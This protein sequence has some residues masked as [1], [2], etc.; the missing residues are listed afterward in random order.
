MPY[1]IR[2]L[3]NKDLYKVV[4]KDT[5]EVHSSGSTYQNAIKQVRLLYKLERKRTGGM[6][7]E[8]E[9][10]PDTLVYKRINGL[11]RQIE[12]NRIYLRKKYR[13]RQ[14]D[15]DDELEDEET[16]EEKADFR[17]ITKINNELERQIE[18]LKMSNPDTNILD[19]L[20]KRERTG[21]GARSSR[22]A[23]AGG[24]R[25][26][27]EPVIP[28]APV[29]ISPNES[30]T[31]EVY[32]NDLFPSFSSSSRPSSSYRPN[33]QT[34]F[35]TQPP[36]PPDDNIDNENNDEEVLQTR[37]E[38]L[39]F[40]NDIL[41][42]FNNN[43]DNI[44]DEYRRGEEI[45]TGY[46]NSVL[47]NI[48]RIQAE[49]IEIETRLGRG[50]TGRGIT[51]IDR[52]STGV[53]RIKIN[54]PAKNF[55]NNKLVPLITNTTIRITDSRKNSGT[56]RSQV[57]GYGNIRGK[58][59]GEFKNNTTYPDLYR[60]L[61]IFGMKIVPDYIPFTAIQVNHN[62]K[63]K[64]H[65]DGNNIG[66]SLAVSFGDF[67]GGELVVGGKDYQTKEY[68]II[69][70]GALSEHFNRPI[71]GD[72]YSLVF[73][74]SAPKKYT[75]EDV[76]KLHSKILANIKLMKGE[77][78]M[79]GSIETDQFDR[80]EIVSLP[81]F[82]SVKVDLP[83]YMYKVLPNINGKSPPY[84]Y[85]LVIPIT[86]S[87][88]LSTRKAET[89]L[90]INQKPIAKPIINIAPPPADR[91]LLSQF[92]PG[93][94][95]KIKTYYTKVKA[96]ENKNLDTIDKD[97]YEIVPRGKPLPCPK[98]LKPK[99]S[100]TSAVD[101]ES[102]FEEEEVRPKPRGRPKKQPKQVIIQGTDEEPSSSDK[103][104]SEDDLAELYLTDKD[105]FNLYVSN[106]N[107]YFRKYGKGLKNNI[108][109][110]NKMPNKWIEYV[111]A[112]AAK[113]NM[114]YN[115][116]LKD[117]NMK[118]GYKNGDTKMGKGITNSH[119]QEEIAELYNEKQLGANAG[120]K[121]ISL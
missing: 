112:Y 89:S 109:V 105:A 39:I 23:P 43:E 36:S 97:Q 58:G 30:I 70:N 103:D 49:I 53:M 77:G 75:D 50:I 45:A 111:K 67:T 17:R 65:I 66:L 10:E 12:D 119:Q 51:D 84:K 37:I 90:G 9:E 13:S 44:L 114:K 117:P 74:V 1:I 104:L 38:E 100:R 64:K 11:R 54:D 15:D 46:Y 55:L 62:Y 27:P 32:G 78:L 87:R 31:T 48:R 19:R 116:A 82:R 120:K 96:N 69:F 99:R 61:L 113:N 108:S 115:E 28:T 72:R 68:P 60:A 73:F 118:A 88:N 18:V 40:Y 7:E 29:S 110:N 4:N 93:D 71:S 6:I 26:A 106:K 52:T 94:R 98:S 107:A 80:N 33:S 101:F 41:A 25:V 95:E 20:K 21:K 3:P 56:G 81:E 76:Y 16:E 47:S 91:P 57:F 42:R 85:R 14:I 5:K 35:V 34:S 102:G 8:E 59:F 79:G 22:V 83:T 86:N 2:K 92:S 121:Y 63:T 24:A